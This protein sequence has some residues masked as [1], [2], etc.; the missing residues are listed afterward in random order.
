MDIENY[1]NKDLKQV[2]IKSRCSGNGSGSKGGSS[3]RSDMT[4]HKCVKKG[5]L[6][7]YRR[8]KGNGSGGNPPKKSENDLSEQV[9]KKPVV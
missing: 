5:H 8:S 2:D 4:F 9:T 3:T 1:I 7:K 6:K